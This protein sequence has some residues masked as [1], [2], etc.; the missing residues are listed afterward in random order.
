M[1]VGLLPF[2]TTSSRPARE[3]AEETAAGHLRRFGRAR[4]CQHAAQPLFAITDPEA[5]I[6]R[7]AVEVEETRFQYLRCRLLQLD[8]QHQHAALVDAQDEVISLQ[9]VGDL[10]IG[11]LQYPV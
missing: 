4:S 1:S 11:V 5:E 9:I 8:P 2:M 6:R 3:P 10:E 7:H